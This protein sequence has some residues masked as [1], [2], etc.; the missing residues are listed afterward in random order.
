MESCVFIFIVDYMDGRNQFTFENVE[1][2]RINCLQSS[3][4]PYMSGLML[5]VLQIAILL[6][7]SKSHYI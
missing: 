1:C 2:T 6:N 4:V 5:Q 3:T 7:H